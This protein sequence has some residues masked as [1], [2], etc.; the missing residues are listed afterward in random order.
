MNNGVIMGELSETF[1]SRGI[2]SERAD[3]MASSMLPRNACRTDKRVSCAIHVTW[4]RQHAVIRDE[5]TLIF[6]AFRGP[7]DFGYIGQIFQMRKP[8]RSLI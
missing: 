4:T 6:M 1:S 8:A 7:A 3:R 2:A 5:K